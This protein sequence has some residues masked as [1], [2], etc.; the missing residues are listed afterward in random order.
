MM[1]TTD[2]LRKHFQ[3]TEFTSWGCTLAYAGL[4]PEEEYGLAQSISPPYDQ[5]TVLD[6][7]TGGGRIAIDLAKRGFGQVQGFDYVPEFI[8][9]ARTNADSRF[10]NLS[11]DLGDVRSLPVASSSADVVLMWGQVLS[12]LPMYEDRM[13]ALNEANR[14]LRP[15]G[16]LLASYNHFP[17]RK[18]NILLQ[19]YVRVMRLFT[20]ERLP[21]RSLPVLKRSKKFYLG[22]LLPFRNQPHVYWHCADE[23]AFEVIKAGFSITGIYS[24]YGLRNH[25][26]NEYEGLRKGVL[27]I[28]A[29]KET[30]GSS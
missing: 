3:T 30:H 4:L 15:G 11:F 19:Y 9:Q 27:Y 26:L 13:A 25:C 23:A 10:P 16:H 29:R 1:N 14:V 18:M 22:A 17:S 20:R 12:F 8:E 2:R 5:L 21:I 24:S 7:G 6:L 28:A